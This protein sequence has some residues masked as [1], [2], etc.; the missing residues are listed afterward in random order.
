MFDSRMH[1]GG[2]LVAAVIACA[3]VRPAWALKWREVPFIY[4]NTEVIEPGRDKEYR[5]LNQPKWISCLDRYDTFS[6]LS[7]ERP[8]TARLP[9]GWSAHINGWTDFNVQGW[10]HDR[11][12]MGFGP[13][14]ACRNPLYTAGGTGVSFAIWSS[15]SQ[16]ALISPPIPLEPGE[17]TVRGLFWV[18]AANGP[19]VVREWLGYAHL[20][21]GAAEGGQIYR[22]H[23]RPPD[24]INGSADV[25]WH[26]I[27]GPEGFTQ[28]SAGEIWSP[29]PPSDCPW[30]HWNQ[31]LSEGD[32]YDR[33]DIY[34]GGPGEA[35][36]EW[37]AKSFTFQVTTAA[38]YHLAFNA[39]SDHNPQCADPNIP[40]EVEMWKK[41][42]TLL[43]VDDLRVEQ[44]GQVIWA[45]DFDGPVWYGDFDAD[46]DVDVNDFA[47][48]QVCFNGPSRPPSD[49]C[50][51]DADADA[52]GDVDVNDFSI[53]QLCFNGTNRPP[54]DACPT[55][56][57]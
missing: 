1:G 49:L 52:D 55:P 27:P 41:W 44:H 28:I 20:G 26:N 14:T 10:V 9:V 43:L 11:G 22:A 21:L 46:C 15:H 50:T 38:E 54:A 42:G 25:A 32:G 56:P 48:F 12:K 5:G 29:C 36:G 4:S 53:F 37:F 16:L 8:R 30:E 13:V 2:R 17:V 45:E 18:G 3:M 34:T 23:L 57:R 39:M 19:D 40:P 24:T 47:V 33:R 31:N 35:V 7:E 51:A 6:F